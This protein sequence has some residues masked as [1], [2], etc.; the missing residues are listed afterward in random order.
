MSTSRT[1]G[2]DVDDY[3]LSNLADHTDDPPTITIYDPHEGADLST[4]W[5][6]IDFDHAVPEE[7]WR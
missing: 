1:E 2:R 3:P 6:T 5:A 7:D 4:T